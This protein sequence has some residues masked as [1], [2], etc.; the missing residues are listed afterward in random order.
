MMLRSEDEEWQ[1]YGG[2]SDIDLLDGRRI[3]F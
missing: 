2:R 3:V 1:E